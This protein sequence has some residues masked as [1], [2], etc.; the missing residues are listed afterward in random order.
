[1]NSRVRSRGGNGLPSTVMTSLAVTSSAG[2]LMT[3][4][5]T[6]TRPCVIHSSA[7]R[8]EARPARATTL[9]M[10][11]PDFF[12]RGGRGG[13][14]VEIGLALAIGAAAAE[15]RTLCKDLAV[16]LVVAARP[17]SSPRF[18][19]RMLLPVGAAFARAGRYCVGPR[20]G[21]S[22]FGRS[23][24]RT[25]LART[26][27]ARTFIAAAIVARIGQSAA[28]RNCAHRHGP[29]GNSRS[30]RLLALLPRF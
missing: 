20:R 28:C 24:V 16:V 8:R 26:R 4:P 22:N 14:L 19:A 5:L 15:R 3:R 17:T 18:A 30:P 29:D 7:S 27:K 6:V 21:R 1:M 2:E 12:S 13:A 10:R 23:P 11:S 9:A 25:I